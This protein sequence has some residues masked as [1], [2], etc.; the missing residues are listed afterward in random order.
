MRLALTFAVLV[1][2]AAQAAEE[3]PQAPYRGSRVSL[4]NAVS[5][6]SFDRGAQLTY[7]P[8]DALTLGLDGR[9][10]FSE[11][12]FAK[13]RVD[14]S[15]ELTESN[16]TTRSGEL[17]LG[18]VVLGAG[19]DRAYTVPRAELQLSGDVSLRLPTSLASRADT[20]VLGLEPSF[21]VARAF[22]FRGGASVRYSFSPSLHFHRFTTGERISP[23]I[24]GCAP[25]SVECERFLNT[26]GRNAPFSHG[27]TLDGGVQL[28]SWL[29]LSAAVG[30]QVAHLYPAATDPRVSLVPQEPTDALFTNIFAL[31]A[32]FTPMPSLSVG[33]G[34]STVNPQLAPDS[35]R[36]G[37]FFNRYTTLF[38]ELRFDPAGLSAQLQGGSTT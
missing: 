1:A 18:D 27:H 34:A 26:G 3:G 36:Y 11:R 32:T 33:L 21:R 16:I 12:F 38:L 22:A 2:L 14:L 20:L 19:L 25:G 8:Y 28:L 7:D 13:G 24:V 30:V 4:R 35:S 6:V 10:W 37:L 15:R 17:L 29:S 23:L 5:T 31:E 9:W